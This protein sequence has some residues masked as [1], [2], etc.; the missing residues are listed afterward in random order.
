[1][2]KFDPLLGRPR[3]EDEKFIEQTIEKHFSSGGGSDEL[4]KV[5]A[6]DS[7]SGYLNGKLV[8]GSN[9][10]LTEGN[11]GGNETLTI[12]GQAGSSGAP[13]DASFVTLATNAT[14]TAERVLT[15]TANQI[16]VTDN[17]AGSTVVLST[18]QNIH[19]AASPTF[20]GLTLSGL[21]TGG[22]V[23]NTAGVL[24]TE[25][26]FEYDPATDRLILPNLGGIASKTDST[27][28]NA[29]GIYNAAGESIIEID[30]T[31]RRVLLLGAGSGASFK[32]AQQGNPS[33]RF[34]AF[35]S[36]AAFN[37]RYDNNA[38]Q[39]QFV[40]QNKGMT[41]SNQGQR[42]RFQLGTSAVALTNAAELRVVSE[43]SW[44]TT[45]STQ[46]AIV[47]F[48]TSSAGA[49]P[50]EK[51]RVGSGSTG[52]LVSIGTGAIATALLHLAAGTATANT[53]PL[54]FTTGT[55]LT[56]AEAGAMEFTT[57]DLFFTITTGAARK[58]LLM[59]DP[60]GGLTSGRVP[61]ATT[62]GRLT[63]DADLTFATDTLTATK[64]VGTTSVKVG[65]AAGFI[66]SDG[67]AGATG[68]FTTADAKTVT[69]KDGIITAIV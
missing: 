17:G 46:N 5:S 50:T 55:S 35:D 62:N 61:F 25:T 13:A 54:K 40:I 2:S 29:L 66:S 69:V 63:D 65:T 6:N 1:M 64:V 37:L 53:A 47:A 15:G 33:T 52:G 30:T 22:V 48:Y 44:T 21:T 56:T 51:M 7:T 16:V 34:F 10:T 4:V 31:N 38:A 3:T 60:V 27:S 14:L 36:A 58:R 28:D 67:S 41:G 45:A 19:T 11:D 26:G 39:G 68:T 32:V 18:P 57:D 24:T 59:A 43:N 23:Y 12:A 20:A 49:A 42:F 9:I 8:A